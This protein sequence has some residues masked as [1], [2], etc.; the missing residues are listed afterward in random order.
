MKCT[1]CGQA[2]ESEGSPC[3][4]T[5][6]RAP[7]LCVN[8]LR[9]WAQDRGLSGLFV[10]AIEPDD[11]TWSFHTWGKT[12]HWKIF[13]AQMGQTFRDGLAEAMGAKDVEAP[14][15]HEDY[16]DRTQE[17]WAVEKDQLMQ[18]IRELEAAE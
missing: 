11:K 18:R 8:D 3:A 16:R 14:V 15:T 17:S 2:L 7:S 6:P 10:V 9:T 4:C 12:P 13:L 1:D 5:E